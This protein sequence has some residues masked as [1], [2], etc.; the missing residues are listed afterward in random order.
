MPANVTA[1]ASAMRRS[2]VR[3]SSAASS[4]GARVW[5]RSGCSFTRPLVVGRGA[6]ETPTPIQRWDPTG[7][8]VIQPQ[9]CGRFHNTA[10]GGCRRPLAPVSSS[11][12]RNTPDLA[13]RQAFRIFGPWHPRSTPKRMG[14]PLCDAARQ[15]RRTTSLWLTRRYQRLFPARSPRRHGAF[16][17]RRDHRQLSAS[18][19]HRR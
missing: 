8:F 12:K 11:W 13:V 9:H 17:L 5:R 10:A 1:S 14:A 6:G 4:G 18:A 19:L 2:R 16:R 3:M 15:C 7:H